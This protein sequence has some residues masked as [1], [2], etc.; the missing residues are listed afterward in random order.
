[1]KNDK[2][3]NPLQKNTISDDELDVVIGA[4]KELYDR[5]NELPEIEAL[6]SIVEVANSKKGSGGEKGF[7]LDT[8]TKIKSFYHENELVRYASWALILIF[9]S[10]TALT[11]DVSPV[12]F[13]PTNCSAYAATGTPR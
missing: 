1:M 9:L 7:T 3:I 5:L 11:P 6:D 10:T 2:Q 12:I 13:V 8:I 4:N